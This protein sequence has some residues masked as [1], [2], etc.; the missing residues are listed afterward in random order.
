[1]VFFFNF[2][3][4]DTMK[5]IQ[6]ISYSYGKYTEKEK[7]LRDHVFAVDYVGIPLFT[8]CT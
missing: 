1:M 8:F 3:H 4:K 6:L 2:E 5:L 7:K